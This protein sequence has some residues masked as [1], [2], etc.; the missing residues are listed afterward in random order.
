M[1]RV[2][3]WEIAAAAATLFMFAEAFLPRLLAPGPVDAA[4]E[5]PESI[6]LR[7]LWLPFYAL[8]GLGLLA[9]GR[10]A[11]R[12]ILGSPWLILLS[13]LAIAST[14]WSIDPEL[15]FRR[16]VA[17]LA[18]TLLGVY[19]AAR[20][21]WLTA[22]R[23]FGGVWLALMAASF[24]TALVFPG[25][26]IMQDIHPGAWSGAWAEKNQLGGHAARAAFLFA[27]L[28][29]RDDSFRKTWSVA[30]VLSLVLVVLSASATAVLASALA[31]GVL[32]AAWWMLK[33]RTWSLAL[34]W[35]GASV[36][37]STLLVY[38]LA[39]DMLLGAIGRE[40]TLTGRTGIWAE[41]GTAISEKPAL[42]YGYLAFWGPDSDLRY[43]L[44]QA[45]EWKAASGHNG[46]LDLAVSL[47]LVGVAIYAV[48]VVF[49]GWR[50]AKLSTISPA[51]VFAIGFLAQFLLVAM[52][53]SII[54]A[55]NSILWATYAFVSCKMAL[56]A[57]RARKTLPP[58]AGEVRR[59]RDRGEPR[60]RESLPSA[61]SPASRGKN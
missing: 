1:T 47:G 30:L 51:G 45:V 54:L 44:Q 6:F 2:S 50:A 11:W 33:G 29:W 5:V 21:D 16:G 27:F 32:V 26:G 56:E 48:D 49:T 18:T 13:L 55:Q 34:A 22:L 46:W 53:E 24:L 61:A 37:G 39:P 17:V 20:F 36:I 9:A 58:L 42:G 4:G 19:L 14:A 8:V 7:Y 40:P 10:E 12:A 52:S 3:R 43:W 23:L 31:L 41:L 35:I 38:V 60:A 15:S 57:P 59:S 28:A 25:F